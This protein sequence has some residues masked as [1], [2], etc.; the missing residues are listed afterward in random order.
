MKKLNI[1]T[2]LLLILLL[3]FS[4]A[5]CKDNNSPTEASTE[6]IF[7]IKELVETN[8]PEEGSIEEYFNRCS[9]LSIENDKEIRVSSDVWNEEEL[10]NTQVRYT[11]LGSA[12]VNTVLYDKEQRKVLGVATSVNIDNYS[13]EAT[14]ANMIYNVSVFTAAMIKGEKDD[15]AAISSDFESVIESGIEM[16]RDDVKLSLSTDNTTVSMI[17][18]PIEP[19]E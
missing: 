16:Y 18:E 2:A 3:T 19:T 1:I 10:D 8:P 14:R 4:L 12:I 7:E 11:S 9:A 15:V 13:D 5:G 6:G 17:A